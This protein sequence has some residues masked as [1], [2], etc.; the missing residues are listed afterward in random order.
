MPGLGSFME[1]GG[2]QPCRPPPRWPPAKEPEDCHKSQPLW[3]PAGADAPWHPAWALWHGPLPTAC[4]P[5][6]QELPGPRGILGQT[7][8]GEAEWWPRA[9]MGQPVGGCWARGWMN[10]EG[11]GTT[12]RGTVGAGCEGGCGAVGCPLQGPRLYL[13]PGNPSPRHPWPWQ[14]LRRSR[15]RDTP[16]RLGCTHAQPPPLCTHACMRVHTPCHAHTPVHAHL[17]A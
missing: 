11:P 15:Q 6:R 10:T 7:P 5:P 12:P 2:P 8:R 4:P 9:P 13:H 1:P 14:R 16:G 3:C 17:H